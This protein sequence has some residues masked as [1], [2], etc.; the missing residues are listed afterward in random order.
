MHTI[1]P[2]GFVFSRVFIPGNEFGSS[3]RLVA[4]QERRGKKGRAEAD[5]YEADNGVCNLNLKQKE[6]GGKKVIEFKPN[7][8]FP[9]V[10][11]KHSS[12]KWRMYDKYD[13]IWDVFASYYI[14]RN[15]EPT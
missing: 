12:W 13:F 5:F 11:L 4:Q 14:K 6:R 3:W 10:R 7:A 2:R 9:A 1:I 8:M 15:Y